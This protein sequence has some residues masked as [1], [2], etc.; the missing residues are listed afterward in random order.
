MYRALSLA[1]LWNT[2]RLI[3]IILRQIIGLTCKS[4]LKGGDSPENRLTKAK[5]V[6]I[7]KQIAE[8]I[9]A[10]VLYHFTS[11]DVA[12]G[13]FMMLIWPLFVA[14][15]CVQSEP[16]MNTWVWQPWKALDKIGYTTGIQ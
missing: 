7:I 15:D 11:D 14:S 12:V 6:A 2:Y 9:C 16:N 3:R 5:G 10:S 1:S 4:M 8:N 13:G